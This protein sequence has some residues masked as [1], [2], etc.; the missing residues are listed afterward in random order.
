MQSANF[1]PSYPL[2]LC[3]PIHVTIMLK[4]NHLCSRLFH[5]GRSQGI[6]TQG[7]SVPEQS[8]VRNVNCCKLKQNKWS[9]R[10]PTNFARVPELVFVWFHL[11]F[12]TYSSKYELPR[13]FWTVITKIAESDVR[14]RKKEH[15]E[16]TSIRIC[17]AV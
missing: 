6:A 17:T 14:W 12:V 3:S 9:K 5:A 2:A 13:Y 8:L 16:E 10:I 1:A 7:M 15:Y 4:F 11:Y